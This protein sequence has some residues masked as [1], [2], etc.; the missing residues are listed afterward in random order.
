M[1]FLF[2]GIPLIITVSLIGYFISPFF[3]DSIKNRGW[4]F[5]V[6]VPCGCTALWLLAALIFGLVVGLGQI[7]WPIWEPF[8]QM[9]FGG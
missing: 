9:F 4:K 7:L 6:G 3:S 5:L 2:C 8:I 1:Y